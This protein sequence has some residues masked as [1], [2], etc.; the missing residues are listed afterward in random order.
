MPHLSRF[1]VR[2]IIKQQN[3]RNIKTHK[4]KNPISNHCR[5]RLFVRTPTDPYTLTKM[6]FK[7]KDL[8][9]SRPYRSVRNTNTSTRT[10]TQKSKS[11]KHPNV[12]NSK[13][14]LS[15]LIS[16]THIQNT[17]KNTKEYSQSNHRRWC[18]CTSSWRPCSRSNGKQSP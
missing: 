7:N 17:P 14:K 18:R 15:L 10:K 9:T 8:K 12:Q 11:N 6:N 16:K 13:S 3:E 4:N 5:F 1:T 2:K